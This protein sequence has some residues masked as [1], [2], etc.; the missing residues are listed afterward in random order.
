MKEYPKRRYLLT[1]LTILSMLAGFVTARGGLAI[2]ATTFSSLSAGD[3]IAGHA[4]EF[5]IMGLVA[6]AIGMV[7]L[8]GVCGERRQAA[9]NRCYTEDR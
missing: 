8:G 3:S 5:L 9:E 6:T 2:L 7:P 1:G 4:L